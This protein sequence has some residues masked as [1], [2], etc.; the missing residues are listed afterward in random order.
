M[1]RADDEYHRMMGSIVAL[2]SKG[3]CMKSQRVRMIGGAKPPTNLVSLDPA[4][5][6]WTRPCASP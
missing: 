3:A 6:S 4:L 5:N 1:S 2:S